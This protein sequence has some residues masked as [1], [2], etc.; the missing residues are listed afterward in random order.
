VDLQAIGFSQI[1]DFITED[2]EKYL[3]NSFQKTSPKSV[4]TRNSIQ[5]FG[6]I[7]PYNT[8]IVSAQIPEHFNFVLDRLVENNLIHR[9]PDSVSVNEYYKGQ[10]IEPHI[11][12]TSSGPIITVLSLLNEATMT[13][14]HKTTEEK[15]VLPPRCLIQ[16]KDEIRK[17]W[18][19]SIDPVPAVRYSVVFRCSGPRH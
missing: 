17:N 16:M 3:I 19:H 12:S 8:H 1:L 2:E 15:V 14:H 6:S 5:R 13:F 4:T 10:I 18:K 7:L 11:D 9:R